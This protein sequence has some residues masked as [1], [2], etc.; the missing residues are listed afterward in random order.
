[1]SSV[2]AIAGMR[3]CVMVV[4]TTHRVGTP[5]PSNVCCT[6][7]RVGA[8][9]WRGRDRMLLIVLG[10]VGARQSGYRNGGFYR[11]SRVRLLPGRR[12]AAMMA[13]FR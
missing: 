12:R 5:I 13:V 2:G 1:M 7:T 4:V 8:I 9:Y 3:G 11:P 6:R 10:K